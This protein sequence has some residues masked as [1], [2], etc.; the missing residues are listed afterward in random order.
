MQ[1]IKRKEERAKD[2]L[3]ELQSGFRWDERV[4][5]I[6]FIITQSIELAR[7]SK[8]PLYIE[9]IDLEGAYDIVSRG[10][11]WVQLREHNLDHVR[12]GF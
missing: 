4:Y 7:V 2:I 10:R 5:G 1:A 12:L 3:G 6:L 9:I 8:K 11:L